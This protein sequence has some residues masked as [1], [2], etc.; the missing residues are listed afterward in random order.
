MSVKSQLDKLKW[1]VGPLHGMFPLPAVGV[2]M[3]WF[4]RKAEEIQHPRAP[5]DELEPYRADPLFYN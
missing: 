3:L 1:Q 4:A 5:V 2:D